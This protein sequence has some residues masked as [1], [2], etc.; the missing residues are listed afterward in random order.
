MCKGQYSLGFNLY[1]LANDLV[2]LCA[3]LVERKLILM[4][5]TIRVNNMNCLFMFCKWIAYN[6]KLK[7]IYVDCC[8]I[9]YIYLYI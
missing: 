3:Y 9:A 5:A 6:V 2:L 4:L 7:A 8:I 1:I